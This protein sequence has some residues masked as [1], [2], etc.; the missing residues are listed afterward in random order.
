MPPNLSIV[1]V[2]DSKKISAKRREAVRLLI[3]AHAIAI[4]L[5]FCSP[6]EIDRLNILGASLEAM[7]RA[8]QACLPAPDF[9]LIDG[10]RSFPDPPF[11]FETIVK[12]DAR[13]HSIAAASIIAKTTR[14]RIMHD[15]HVS[16]P[17]YAWERNM[18][19]PTRYHY[20]ALAEHGPT[21]YHRRTFRLTRR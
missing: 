10:N 17:A 9:L 18:G 1:G 4:G 6:E 21:P 19:Y 2:D 15:L 3:E 11:P 20:D 14:D 12:G 7:R 13:S 8:M 16:Y 5:G